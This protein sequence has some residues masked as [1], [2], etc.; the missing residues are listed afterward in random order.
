M[1]FKNIWYCNPGKCCG[2][3]HYLQ[4]Y[5]VDKLPTAKTPKVACE[6]SWFTVFMVLVRS[7]HFVFWKLHARDLIHKASLGWYRK[8][9]F[10]DACECL[11]LLSRGF[12][13]AW[14]AYRA[15]PWNSM[16][17]GRM[18]WKRHLGPTRKGWISIPV[19]LVGLLPSCRLF[20][21]TPANNVMDCVAAHW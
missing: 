12:N 18:A 1:I 16:I 15:A 19:K 17:L 21:V 11:R 3:A 7:M 4:V 14:V 9:V 6:I 8:L 10:T 5:F 2:F 13:L 20:V